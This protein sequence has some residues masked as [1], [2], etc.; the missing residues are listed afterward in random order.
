MTGVGYSGWTSLVGASE[1]ATP[2]AR[3]D[4]WWVIR[5]CVVG[6]WD[7]GH[8]DKKL[9]RIKKEQGTHCISCSLFVI[10]N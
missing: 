7:E 8:K 4:G 5:V 10:K 1:I 9:A 6:A 3:N 2:S